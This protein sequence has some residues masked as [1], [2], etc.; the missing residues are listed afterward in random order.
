MDDGALRFILPDTK[1]GNVGGIMEG[2]SG[3]AVSAPSPWANAIS[4]LSLL[5]P[6]LDTIPL[7]TATFKASPIL[8]AISP[9][10]CRFRKS[11]LS[12]FSCSSR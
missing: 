8:G 2:Q 3:I 4:E 10:S 7:R 11:A 9:V 6:Q 5:W 12:G 1:P